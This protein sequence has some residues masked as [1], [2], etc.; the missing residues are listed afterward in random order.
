MEDNGN[1][2][3]EHMRFKPVESDGAAVYANLWQRI[4]YGEKI[5]M[6]VSVRWKYYSIAATIAL[7]V[8]SSG[9]F[10]LRRA[11]E[12]PVQYMEVAAVA[13][14]K[15]RVVLPDSTVVWL[16]SNARIRYPQRFTGNFR[17]VDF[18]GD[19]LFR[20]TK[21][22]TQPFVVKMDGLQVKVLGTVFYIAACPSSELIETTLLEGSVALFSD[23][24]P[25]PA[26]GRVLLPD[27]RARYNKKDGRI[28]V[29]K[30]QG[31][32]YA[33]W[34][35][36]EYYFENN[37]LREIM[38]TLERGFNVPIHIE[39]KALGDKVFTAKFTH[40]ETLDRI[41]SILQ[42]SAKYKYSKVKGEIYITG[43]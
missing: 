37:T 5:R 33:S 23:K 9:F 26:A 18:S 12:T 6:G 28:E 16:N 39:G 29:Q 34:V 40:G 22:I 13:G 17:E 11:A 3:L 8:V 2:Y 36:G 35:K 19:A 42:V 1:N 20:V 38:S 15:T 14:S 41:L 31:R 43:K 25:S 32:L 27:E 4:R 30:V 7:L 21:D 10:W 24:N